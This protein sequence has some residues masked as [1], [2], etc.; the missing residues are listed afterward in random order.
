VDTNSDRKKA[1]VLGVAK[2]MGMPVEAPAA[3][4]E[5]VKSTKAPSAYVKPLVKLIVRLAH[6]KRGAGRGEVH[7]EAINPIHRDWLR[8]KASHRVVMQDVPDARRFVSYVDDAFERLRRKPT[9]QHVQGVVNDMKWLV[10]VLSNKAVT[11][12]DRW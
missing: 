3:D 12:R 2:E 8:W 6:L 11:V 9:P 7:P 10:Q 4:P 1:I 5:A